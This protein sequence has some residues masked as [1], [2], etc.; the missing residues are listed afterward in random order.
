VLLGGATAAYLRQQGQPGALTP[1]EGALTGL[2]AGAIGIGVYLVVSVPVSILTSPL[3]R[4]LIERLA[5]IDP[6]IRNAMSG[7]AGASLRLLGGFMVML[8]TSPTFG[9]LG[10]LLGAMAFRK[11]PPLSP[12][13][14]P[15]PGAPGAID[16]PFSREG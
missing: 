4:A 14:G 9:A 6:E 5:E 10:G 11:S 16:V 8:F 3:E 7:A 12:P 2:V 15:P 13:D 1:S